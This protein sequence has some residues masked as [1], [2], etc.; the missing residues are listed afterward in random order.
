MPDNMI[1]LVDH[2]L[3]SDSFKPVYVRGMDMVEEAAC[4]LDGEGRE[5]ARNLS[6]VAAALYAQESMRLT[7]RLMQIA[8]WLLLQRAARNGEMPTHKIAAE[9]AK[10]RL[11]MPS[12]GDSVPGWNELPQ[13]FIQLVERSMEL[14]AQI[15]RMEMNSSDRIAPMQ[16]AANGNPVSDQIVLLKTAFGA[17]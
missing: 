7:T 17:S 10:V 6:P 14:Q 8:S 11:D 3:F 16:D 4:Y 9:K 15:S 1:S 5:Q 12:A 13:A 2:R